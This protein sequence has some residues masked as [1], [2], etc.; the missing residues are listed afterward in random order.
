MI[1][2]SNSTPLIALNAINS[3]DL[4]FS[5]Y[6]HI[7]IPEAV[8]QEVVVAGS[9]RAGASAVS[10]ATWIE[11]YT[12]TDQ[13]AVSNLRKTR[14]LHSGES[15]AIIL[16]VELSSDLI[17]LDDRIARRVARQHNLSI[18]GTIGIILLAKDV[19]LTAAAKPL[20]DGLLNAGIYIDAA[21]YERA[22]RLADES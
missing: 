13:H 8:H 10:A 3:L 12:I 7:H 9:G 22:M 2:V 17:L 4:L 5:L 16:A 14:R 6:A 18:I 20:L 19:G 11:R 15:E 21:L 1:V